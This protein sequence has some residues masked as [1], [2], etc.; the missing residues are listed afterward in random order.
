MYEH[1]N[2]TMLML[3]ITLPMIDPVL[4]NR[5]A[6]LQHPADDGKRYIRFWNTETTTAKPRK[7]PIFDWVK[8]LRKA[9][10]KG[11]QL[12]S[13]EK[14]MN[15]PYF[16]SGLERRIRS[17]PE[18]EERRKFNLQ[19]KLCLV[20]MELGT[21]TQKLD[22]TAK[23]VVF[24][25]AKSTKLRRVG[26]M[27]YTLLRPLSKNKHSTCLLHSPVSANNVSGRRLL[28]L[29]SI[30]KMS[31]YIIFLDYFL[32]NSITNLRC[33]LNLTNRCDQCEGGSKRGQSPLWVLVATCVMQHH[34]HPSVSLDP[35]VNV[36]RAN[37]KALVLFYLLDASLQRIFLCDPRSLSC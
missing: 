10:A 19:A 37:M 5:A 17:L 2:F 16:I 36:L 32:P 30:A 31:E 23:A 28:A 13:C 12:A 4:I 11:K 22:G 33:S 20:L 8:K 25:S 6:P 15:T 7:T 14:C 35:Q 27:I 26:V 3:Y 1:G 29:W 21:Q 18:R 9:P 24:I 34:H